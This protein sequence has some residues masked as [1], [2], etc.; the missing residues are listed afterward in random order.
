MAKKN[1]ELNQ[2]ID[3]LEKQIRV[4]KILIHKLDDSIKKEHNKLRRVKY[5]RITIEKQAAEISHING[6]S[7][8]DR[9]R[10]GVDLQP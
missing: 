3:S 4:R 7:P 5:E 8:N 6:I 1:T 10:V 9:G 2:R